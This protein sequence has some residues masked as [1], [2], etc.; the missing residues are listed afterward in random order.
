LLKKAQAAV[1]KT[2]RKNVTPK[3]LFFLLFCL[4]DGRHGWKNHNELKRNICK[5]EK[6]YKRTKLSCDNDATQIGSARSDSTR[7]V[8][9]N[10]RKTNRRKTRPYCMSFG[11]EWESFI[12]LELRGLNSEWLSRIGWRP[13]RAGTG[14]TLADD[15]CDFGEGVDC[16]PTSVLKKHFYTPSTSMLHECRTLQIRVEQANIKGN[17][18]WSLVTKSPINISLKS[19]GSTSR[20]ASRSALTN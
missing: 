8:K 3:P 11:G 10:R 9:V 18:T 15:I 13:F 1:E 4:F 2:S 5:P 19:V 17:W 12:C 16:D 7:V 14:I 6:R 20:R